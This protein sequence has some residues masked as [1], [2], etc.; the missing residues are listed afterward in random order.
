MAE[1]VRFVSFINESA[2]RA[3]STYRYVA[4]QPNWIV[5]AVVLTFLL[6]LAI[7]IAM[8]FMLALLGGLLVFAVLVAVNAVLN[9]F[10]NVMPARDGRENV[11]IIRRE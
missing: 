7:P 9:G 8:L 1:Q 6:I 5:R 4:R 2:G 11:R 3:G 10:R